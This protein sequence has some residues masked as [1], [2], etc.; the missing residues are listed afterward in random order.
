[1]ARAR[2]HE[3]A[4]STPPEQPEPPPHGAVVPVVGYRI[5]AVEGMRETYEVVELEA[6]ATLDSV[7][8]VSPRGSLASTRTRLLNAREKY[9]LAHPKEALHPLP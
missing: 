8:V 4:P 2:H 9:E 1:M 5:R 6:L 3:S 7:K